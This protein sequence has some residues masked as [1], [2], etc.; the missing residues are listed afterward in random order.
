MLKPL[1]CD[2]SKTNLHA[3]SIEMHRFLNCGQRLNSHAGL[4][5]GGGYHELTQLTKSCVHVDGLVIH[6]DVKGSFD[7]IH[8]LKRHQGNQAAITQASIV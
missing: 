3:A 2:S 8:Q 7:F 1:I 4:F 5:D 6:I